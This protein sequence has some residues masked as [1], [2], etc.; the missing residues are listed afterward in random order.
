MRARHGGSA[1]MALG[2]LRFI[3]YFPA[4]ATFFAE[5]FCF[6]AYA[7]DQTI[8]NETSSKNRKP[9]RENPNRQNA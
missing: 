5:A 7:G 2:R 1:E 8:E 6:G 4:P 3:R 9:F